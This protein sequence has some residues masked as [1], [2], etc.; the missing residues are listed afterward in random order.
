MSIEGIQTEY[1][2]SVKS[3]ETPNDL[4][5]AYHELN[6][7]AASGDIS[8]VGEEAR[9]DPAL[10]TFKNVNDLAKS[11][12]ETKKLVGTIKHAP[13]KVEEY[14]FTALKD[15]HPGVAKSVEAT[16]KFIATRLHALD[17][18][19]D[20]A[21]KLQQDILMGLHNG[22]VQQDKVRADKA[23]EVETALRGEWL[24]NYDKNKANVENI[25]KRLGLEDYGKE[26]SGD[27]IKLK[28]MHKLTSLLS[29][30]SIGK[31]GDNTSTSVDTK[32]KEGAKKALDELMSDIVK[33]GKTH[34]FNDEK[35]KDHVA[36]V[37]KYHEL[38]EVAFS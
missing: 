4:A 32:T 30:D 36:T 27:P 9:K 13:A 38:T 31:L 26:I 23:K 3:F 25:F 24:E 21:D 37:K 6:A 20:R 2:E 33:T 10:S 19:N 29:E 17:I 22:M 18:D 16:Q 11:F 28:A 1:A 14:K 5:K 35:H 7:R 12:I 15:L 34:P 8:L